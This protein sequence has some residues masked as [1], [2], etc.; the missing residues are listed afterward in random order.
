MKV[1]IIAGKGDFPLYIIEQIK[2]IFVLC[3]DQNSSNKLFKKKSATVSLFDPESWIKILKTN[4]ITHIVMAGKFDRPKNIKQPITE[5][6]V[7]LLK[8]INHLGDNS[9]LN[10]IE[11]F[12]NDHGFQILP[13]YSIIKDCFFPK[14][15]YLENQMSLNLKNFVKE[16]AATGIDLLNAISKFDVGQSVIVSSKL[17]YAIEGQEGT[18]LMIDRVGHIYVHNKLYSDYGPVLIKIPKKNQKVNL[19]LPVIGLDTVKKCIKFGFSALVV[20]SKGTLIVD[21]KKVILHIKNNN[22]CVYAI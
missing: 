20:S 6:G 7:K 8:K 9:A 18:D 22:F 5:E 11:K 1:A 12:F 4:N 19:D 3:V 21:L 15:F 2:D 13:I 10:L 17:I 16:S 14:G